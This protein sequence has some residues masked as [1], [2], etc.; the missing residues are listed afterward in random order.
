MP[1]IGYYAIHI[2]HL[3]L[4]LILLVLAIRSYLST[5]VSA[6]FFLVVA[7]FA[8]GIGHIFADLYFYG[9]GHELYSEIFDIIGLS[10]LIVAVRK[11]S[12]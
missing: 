3:I 7:F 5:R 1:T 6:I 2:V 9:R 11:I 12:D 8:I 4:A 10:A